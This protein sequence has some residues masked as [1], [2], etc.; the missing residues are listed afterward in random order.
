MD[1]K[2]FLIV[3][4]VIVLGWFAAG[5][6]YNLRRGNGV[7]RWLQAGLPLVGEKTTFRWLGS[8]VAQLEINKPKKPFRHVNLMVVLQP[9]DTFLWA[10]SALQGRRD[11]MIFRSQLASTPRLSLELA[12]P[13][14]W[15]GRIAL[16]EV[17][18][19]GW[20]SETYQGFQLSSPPGS[21]E[22]AKQLLSELE[23]PLSAL[24]IPPLRLGIRADTQLFEIHLPLPNPKKQDAQAFVQAIQAL[25]RAASEHN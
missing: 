9:R 17:A 7:L 21:M 22:T 14:T 10:F 11:L 24:G 4:A 6:L 12:V 20:A 3:G 2:A 8:S 15:T 23:A 19:K 1:P 5:L 18:R 25:A 13:T 16:H